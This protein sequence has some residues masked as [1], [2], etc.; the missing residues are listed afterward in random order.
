M[1]VFCQSGNATYLNVY[2]IDFRSITVIKALGVTPFIANFCDRHGCS[3]P[4]LANWLST[5]IA[6]E[7]IGRII[8]PLT[9]IAT[10]II[11]Y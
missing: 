5:L 9:F 7:D 4:N 6:D 3:K 10:C 2:I 1:S 8:S 11:L